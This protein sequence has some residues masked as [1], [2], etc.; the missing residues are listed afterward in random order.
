MQ[1]LKPYLK[2]IFDHIKETN[3]PVDKYEIEVEIARKRD[4]LEKV[5]LNVNNFYF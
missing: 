5:F 4:G 3:R 1:Y 2:Y